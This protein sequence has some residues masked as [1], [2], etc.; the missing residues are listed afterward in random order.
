[1]NDP[2][3]FAH[4]SKAAYLDNPRTYAPDLGFETLL[5]FANPHLDTFGYVAAQGD[6]TIVAL[7]GSDD[8][9]DWIANLSGMLTVCQDLPGR[10][11]HG[12]ARAFGS[13]W[14]Q[15]KDYHNQLQRS[16]TFC[17]GHSLGGALA[18]LAAAHLQATET[19]T[20]GQPR[21]GNS[22]FAND[23]PG[24]LNRYVHGYDSVPML[25]YAGLGYVHFGE[26]H[27]IEAVRPMLANQ[28]EHLRA[29]ITDHALDRYVEAL[30]KLEPQ[31]NP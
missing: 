11:H 27:Y 20:Y 22:D 12:F 5:T 9:H 2:L 26:L 25:P 21:V 28:K 24:T 13:V 17:C 29:R 10:V 6:R 4:A 3:F 14:G 31:E 1:M 30:E 16:Q 15:I 8:P 7:R 23:F 18:V 19:Y